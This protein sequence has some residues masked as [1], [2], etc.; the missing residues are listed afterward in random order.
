M[1]LLRAAVLFGAVAVAVLPGGIAAA[2]TPSVSATPG[3]NMPY[4]TSTNS[5]VRKIAQCGTIM[6]A[7]GTF[8]TVGA[9]GK[10]TLTRHNVFAF[11][12]TTG[13]ISTW[14]PNTNGTVNSITFSA[15]CATAYL[16][17]SFST[18]HGTAIKNLAK[19]S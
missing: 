6:Y 8:S 4:V 14:D 5:Y 9:I 17:G 11:N 7:V 13:A 1:K 19:V 2:S 18:V 12:A 3:A 15:D 10:S 16:G